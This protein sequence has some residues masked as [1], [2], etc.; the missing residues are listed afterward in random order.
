MK[1]DQQIL[2]ERKAWA[3]GRLLAAW[4]LLAKATDRDD[5]NREELEI[6][7]AQLEEAKAVAH[8]WAVD[9]GAVIEDAGALL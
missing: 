7:E 9:V 5:L 6:Y 4:L 1:S 2:Q 8:E 3:R